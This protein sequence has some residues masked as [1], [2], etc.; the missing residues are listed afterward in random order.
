[1]Q[2][3]AIGSNIIVIS[4]NQLRSDAII[5]PQAGIRTTR[6]QVLIYHRTNGRIIRLNH[7][8]SD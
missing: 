8:L 4:I 3:Y 2:A 7:H 6:F 1:M 5:E